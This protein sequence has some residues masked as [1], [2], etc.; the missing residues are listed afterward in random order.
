MDMLNF[1]AKGNVAALIFAVSSLV[2][3][4][5]M[6][7]QAVTS[8]TAAVHGKVSNP[9]GYP[10]SKGDVKL[11]TDR[12][13]DSKD[14]KYEFSFPIDT[15]GNFK[16]DKIAP[17]DYLAVV[18][19]DG[20]TLDFQPIVL[21][22]GDEKVLDF[23]MSRPE[24]IKSL[25]AEERAAI[26]ENKKHN[27]AV[28]AENSK[29]TNINATLLQA[30]A[31]EK[32]GK[33]EEAV[34]ALK[35]L[36]SVRPDESV[37]WASLGEAQL[38][39]AEASVKAA[40]TAH[41][42]TN[43][44]AILQKYTDSATSYQKAIDLNATSKKPSPETVS[45]SY[46]NM[47]KALA[48]SGKLKEGA[49]AYESAVKALPST[50]GMAYY[51]EAATFFNAGKMDEAAAAADK[52]IAADPKRP[53]SYY[54]KA[55]SLIPKATMDP[56]TNKFILPPGCLEAYQQYLELEPTGGH[57]QEIKDLLAN[58]GQPVK[59]SFKAGRK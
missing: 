13:A 24:Y 54:I 19:V 48:S 14:R 8:V 18:Y 53:E 58:L 25:S 10:V 35:N 3:P 20:K 44:P 37:I 1:R 50:A 42:A 26:E 34:T 49:E 17:G 7:A 46:L 5:Q 40:R 6:R 11:T 9:G 47:G 36:T 39:S 23:D 30:R 38:A 31:D 45:S 22:A 33:T 56:K 59:N 51:N 55:Q 4:A 43:D 16:G 32:A 57:S 41:T 21:K 15:T 29:I 2:V 28:M 27:A 12:T 52:A